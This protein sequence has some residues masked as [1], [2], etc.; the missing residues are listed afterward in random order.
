M[1]WSVVIDQPALATGCVHWKRTVPYLN[2]V[3]RTAQTIC[4]GQQKN[5]MVL[6]SGYFCDYLFLWSWFL[7]SLLISKPFY[8]FFTSWVGGG[9]WWGCWVGW[10]DMVW[11]RGVVGVVGGWCGGGWGV[12]GWWGWGLGGGWG[13]G[14]LVGNSLRAEKC[15]WQVQ[16]VPLNYIGRSAK[17]PKCHIGVLQCDPSTHILPHYLTDTGPL[18]W[19]SQ[20]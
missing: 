8:I 14:G 9:G 12:G 17:G 2:V 20:C 5:I 4:T 6:E 18:I 3:K 15:H 7:L 13:G 11:G 1:G 19:L 16:N 10:R